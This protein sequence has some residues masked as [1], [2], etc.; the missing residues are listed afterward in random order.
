VTSAADDDHVILTWVER[1][2]PEVEAPD[3]SEGFGSKLV[4]RSVA[5]Q[6]GGSIVYEWSAGGV[7]ITLRMSRDRLMT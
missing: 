1:G 4:R 7:I 6:L 2:G 3:A 5:G